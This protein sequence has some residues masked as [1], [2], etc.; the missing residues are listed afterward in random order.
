M[1]KECFRQEYVRCGKSACR[2]CPHGPYWYAYWRE[3]DRVRKRYVGKN[4]PGSGDRQFGAKETAA[5]PRAHPWDAIFV[6]RTASVRLACEIMGVAEAVS[7]AQWASA[8]RSASRT[9]HPDSG[10]NEEDF[11]RVNAAWYF[12]RAMRGWK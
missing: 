11:K 6:R 10:G 9:H 4:L 2:S 3:G 7:P 1:S 8:F 5:P 12:V